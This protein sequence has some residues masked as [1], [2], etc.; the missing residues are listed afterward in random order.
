MLHK[1]SFELHLYLSTHTLSLHSQLRNNKILKKLT[2]KQ[3]SY[4]NI[5]TAYNCIHVSVC[6]ITNIH[7]FI[8]RHPPPPTS[9]SASLI[10][11]LNR[12]KCTKTRHQL[13]LPAALARNPGRQSNKRFTHSLLYTQYVIA[14]ARQARHVVH[15]NGRL[16]S[17]DNPE[18][19]QSTNLT[20][21]NCRFN[22]FFYSLNLLVFYIIVFFFCEKKVVGLMLQYLLTYDDCTNF[23]H[24]I[25]QTP[26]KYLFLFDEKKIIRKN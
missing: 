20:L 15:V 9:S 1:N 17:T 14:T 24:N 5:L 13:Q 23:E 8:V 25:F 6:I 21:F 11:I 18:C 26:K 4:I 19:S 22:D 3:K 2:A 12:L 7:I 10:V 16:R